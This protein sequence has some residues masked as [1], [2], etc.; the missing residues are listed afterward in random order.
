MQT[1]GFRR[2]CSGTFPLE[3]QLGLLKNSSPLHKDDDAPGVVQPDGLILGARRYLFVGAGKLCR[4]GFL[5]P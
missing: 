1:I 3:M 5:I 2:S 4:G